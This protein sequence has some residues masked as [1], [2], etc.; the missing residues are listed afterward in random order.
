MYVPSRYA[1]TDLDVLHEFIERNGFGLLVSQ[2]EDAP[3]ATHIPFLLDRDHG[4]NGRLVGHVARANP[5]WRHLAGQRALAVFSGP[6]AYISPTW[7]EA[8]NTVPT[9]DYVAVHATGMVETIEDKETLLDIVRRTTDAYES[10]MPAP[11]KLN[12][13]GAFVDRLLDQ[14]VG[15]R[16]RID[17]L[18]GQWKMNQ[19]H[20]AE[21]RAKVIRALETRGTGD[22]AAV[23]R[24]IRATLPEEAAT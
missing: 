10:T 23:A 19:N 6:H 9:W 5:Q 16:L 4:R 8:E 3:F 14:I 11:W 18:E 13:E 7:Y 22:D 20:P 24:L 12:A 17:K 15:F 2:V 21:R 1:V